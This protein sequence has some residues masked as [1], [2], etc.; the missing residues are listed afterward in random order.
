MKDIKIGIFLLLCIILQACYSKHHQV[1]IP[2]AGKDTILVVQTHATTVTTINI[3]VHG[4]INDSCV[5]N[6]ITINK[7]TVDTSLRL[8]WYTSKVM[9]SYHALRTTK[10][11]LTIQFEL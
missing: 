1:T 5:L 8:D 7:G 3:K 4:Y 6:G 11:T 10:G 9:L 2:D